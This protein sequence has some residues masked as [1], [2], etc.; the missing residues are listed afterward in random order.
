MQLRYEPLR[1]LVIYII[2]S[3][4]KCTSKGI[5]MLLRGLVMRML[6]LPLPLPLPLT[7]NPLTLTPN[8]KPL[9]P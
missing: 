5:Y 8:P 7:P 6:A 2:A 4:T 1:G 9:S 3:L